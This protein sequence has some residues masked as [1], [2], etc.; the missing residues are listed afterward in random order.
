[1]SQRE[2][3]RNWLEQSLRADEAT[4]ESVQWIEMATGQVAASHRWP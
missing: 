1:M 2:V 3:S 4:I